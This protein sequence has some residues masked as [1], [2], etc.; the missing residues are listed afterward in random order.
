MYGDNLGIGLNLLG[1]F[2]GFLEGEGPCSIKLGDFLDSNDYE[3]MK[4]KEKLAH[5]SSLLD[6]RYARASVEIAV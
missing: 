2:V 3:D 1:E 4:M 5:K 6:Y